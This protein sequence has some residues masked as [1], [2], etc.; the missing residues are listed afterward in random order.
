MDLV[1][2]QKERNDW[3]NVHVGEKITLRWI[4]EK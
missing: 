2:S 4:S 3:E 1:G